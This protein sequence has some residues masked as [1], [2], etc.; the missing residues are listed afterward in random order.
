MIAEPTGRRRYW[1]VDENETIVYIN[2]NNA[3]VLLLSV[4]QYAAFFSDRLDACRFV[5]GMCLNEHE[6]LITAGGR[7]MP[8]ACKGWLCG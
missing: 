5:L 7:D 2:Q 1:D 6:F 8:T 3:V 4:S